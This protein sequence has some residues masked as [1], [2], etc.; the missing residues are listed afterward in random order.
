MERIAHFIIDRRHYVLSLVIIATLF[1]GYLASKISVKT[2]YTDLLPQN[3]PYIDV[4]NEIRNVFG[5]SNQVL[6]MVQVKDPAKGGKYKDIFNPDTLGKVKFINDELK[7]FQGVDRYKIL[8]IA[9]KKIRN[10]QLTSKG[11]CLRAGHVAR[12]SKNRRAAAQAQA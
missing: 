12:G 3:H 1:F 2:I 4:H 5:G 7:K 8:S 11:L 6:I 10:M 9:E